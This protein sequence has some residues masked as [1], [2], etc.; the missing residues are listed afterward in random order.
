M[1]YD[2]RPNAS[3]DTLSSSRD[4]IRTNFNIIR[5]DFAVD[6]VEFDDADEGKHSQ[7]TYIELATGPVTAANESAIWAIQGPSSAQTELYIR[8]ENIA[9]GALSVPVSDLAIFGVA[10]AG[11]FNATAVAQGTHNVNMTATRNGT[12]LFT[13]NFTNAMTDADYMV[14]ISAQRTASGTNNHLVTWRINTKAAGSIQMA[15]AFRPP[16]GGGGTQ[17]FDPTSWNAI[18]YGGIQ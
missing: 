7:S 14:V 15:F 8:R 9:A 10:A 18:V 13:C 2:P 12:G 4:P 3:G 16:S 6:H 1:T 5:D 11:L 17:L